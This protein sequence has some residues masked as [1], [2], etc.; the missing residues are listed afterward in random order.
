MAL[1]TFVKEQSMIQDSDHPLT[2]AELEMLRWNTAITKPSGKVEPPDVD[3]D[4]MLEVMAEAR[5]Q[6]GRLVTNL[7]ELATI[8]RKH[9]QL[10]ESD[11]SQ[12][13]SRG[14]IQRCIRFP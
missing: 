11:S 2:P 5:R 6:S 14:E 3:Y 4:Y 7:D 1:K 9:G 10:K 12:S 8:A 13:D